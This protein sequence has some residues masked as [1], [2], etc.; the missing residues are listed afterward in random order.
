[1]IFVNVVGVVRSLTRK[2]LANNSTWWK[3]MAIFCDHLIHL[4]IDGQ[5]WAVNH[6]QLSCYHLHTV[7]GEYKGWRII[8][9]VH[10]S[11]RH[12]IRRMSARVCIVELL[13]IMKIY[14]FTVVAQ[15]HKLMGQA[16]IF[17]CLVISLV[18][19]NFCAHLKARPL[20]SPLEYYHSYCCHFLVSMQEVPPSIVVSPL[21]CQI[22]NL[23]C[24]LSSVP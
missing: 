13:G 20:V 2:G 12:H 8:W 14:S 16:F 6:S 15:N 19:W 24:L 7:A 11:H 3:R 21:C 18:I 5:A 17:T 1:M 22:T 10:H 23:Y 4:Q 9:C